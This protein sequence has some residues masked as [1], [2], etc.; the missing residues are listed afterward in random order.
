ME[1]H[2][3]LVVKEVPCLNAG[4]VVGHAT[5]G[6]ATDVLVVN[7]SGFLE[8]GLLGCFAS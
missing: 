6:D 2:P 5:D 1:Q 7:R 4:C 8:F 3:L